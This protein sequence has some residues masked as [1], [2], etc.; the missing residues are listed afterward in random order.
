MP[1]RADR[2]EN[3]AWVEKQTDRLIAWEILQRT[4]HAHYEP[5]GSAELADKIG[6]DKGLTYRILDQNKDTINE[7]LKRR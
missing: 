1:T 6:S 7:R 2:T 4:L 3:E 5:I